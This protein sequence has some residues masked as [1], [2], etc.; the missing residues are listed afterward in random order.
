MVSLSIRLKN[1]SGMHAR[2]ASLLVKEAGKFKSEI[3]II[4]EEK[5]Y[6]AKSIMGILSMGAAKGDS[7]T[8]QAKGTDESEAIEA[9]KNLVNS[10]FGE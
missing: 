9:I 5:E 7:I 3:K 4:K 1:K 6:N 8:F 10:N 2:P